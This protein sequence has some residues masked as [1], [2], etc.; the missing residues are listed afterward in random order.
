MFKYTLLFPGQNDINRKKI[1]SPF[2]SKNKIVQ[3]IFRESSEY[4]G[5]DIWKLIQDDPKKKLKNN[6]YSQLVTLVSSI[7]IYELWK[8]KQCT[9]PNLV[10]GHSLGE[11]TALV[12][13]QSLKLS[14][15]IQLIITRYK[16]MMEAMSK[17]IGLMTAIIGLN[18]RTIRKLLKKYDYSHEVSIACINTD[19]QIVLS[20]ERNSVK[21]INLHC[22]KA[23][24]KN[25]INLYIHP[26]SHCTLMKKASK[27]LL[28]VLKH[29][30]FKIPIYPVI[31]STSLKFQ[32][33]EQAIRISLAK[34]IY[35][36]V[37]WNSI[38]KYI[39]KDIFIFLEVST[40]S[41]LTNLNKNIIKKSLSISLNCQA[42]FLKALKI[43]L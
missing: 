35:S 12:C 42:N 9:H 1:L 4:I 22:K 10:I 18:E 40:K 32:N 34:Q 13:S 8:N 16:F 5:Y 28:Y 23:G 6:K 21:H 31:S 37:R 36:T 24:A 30:T 14:D 26:P 25:I 3:S 15:A 33:S 41:I 19:N 11:Y 38:I 17:K 20:G 43:I 7:A 29:T 2:F 27:K 39:K